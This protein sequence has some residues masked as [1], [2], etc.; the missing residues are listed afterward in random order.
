[1][2]ILSL[3]MEMSTNVMGKE[4]TVALCVTVLLWRNHFEVHSSTPLSPVS[5]LIA[6]CQ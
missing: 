5:Y 4:F 6:A 3:Y 2:T 1:M